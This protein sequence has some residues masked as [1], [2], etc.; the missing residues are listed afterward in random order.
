M[1]RLMPLAIAWGALGLVA[2]VTIAG[3]VTIAALMS[4]SNWCLTPDEG[5]EAPSPVRRVFGFILIGVMGLIVLGG[6]YLMVRNS[7]FR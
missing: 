7:F 2:A 5:L 1:P 4:L 6:L 3:A